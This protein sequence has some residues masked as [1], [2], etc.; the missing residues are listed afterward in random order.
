M[1]QWGSDFLIDVGISEQDAINQIAK[2]FAKPSDGGSYT[3]HIIKLTSGEQTVYE[4]DQY[5][6]HAYLRPT[7]DYRTLSYHD[8]QK[9]EEIISAGNII[10]KSIRLKVEEIL[11]HNKK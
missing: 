5:G 8:E 10:N 6:Y 4:F 7:G 1:E 9:H 3:A 11:K 2:A